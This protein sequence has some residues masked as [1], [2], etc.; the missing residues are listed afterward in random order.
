MEDGHEPIV[1]TGHAVPCER[2]SRIVEG[3]GRRA[4]RRRYG[5]ADVAAQPEHTLPSVVESRVS[6]WVANRYYYR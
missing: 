3:G 1:C 2:S 5:R 6:L 4:P